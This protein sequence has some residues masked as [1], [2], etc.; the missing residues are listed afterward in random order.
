MGLFLSYKTLTNTVAEIIFEINPN[1]PYALIL[2]SNL[3]EMSN[4]QVY[5]SEHLPK[6]TDISCGPNREEVI[7]MLSFYAKKLLAS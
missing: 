4:N 5:F 3:F 1:F 7:S 2:A 6:L